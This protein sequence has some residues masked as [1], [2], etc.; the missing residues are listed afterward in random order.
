MLGCW[1]L[2]LY[3]RS[4][5]GVLG[6]GR[7]GRLIRGAFGGR[8]VFGGFTSLAIICSLIIRFI[9]IGISGTL[10]FV[11][12]A[13]NGLSSKGCYFALAFVRIFIAISFR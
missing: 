8:A 13:S 5:G 7:L 10:S 3:R 1:R 6:W 11:I 9:T 12:L 4:N 2:V